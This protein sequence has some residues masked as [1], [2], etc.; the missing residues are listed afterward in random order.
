MNTSTQ[1]TSTSM[2]QELDAFCHAQAWTP[3]TPNT[4]V[5]SAQGNLG[6][7]DFEIEA[8][9]YRNAGNYA[10]KVVLYG[11]DNNARR[12]AGILGCHPQHTQPYAKLPGKQ[13]AEADL[14]QI[15]NSSIRP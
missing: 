14:Y 12:L 9:R 3:E 13:L 6:E 11:F 7:T 4:D 15:L 8:R 10:F 5:A 2:R 1:L